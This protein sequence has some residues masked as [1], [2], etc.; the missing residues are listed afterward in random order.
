MSE[1]TR[2]FFVCDGRV[3]PMSDFPDFSGSAAKYIY[4][5]FRLE[6]GVPVFVEDHLDR[7]WKT[8]ELEHVSFPFSRKEIL[9]EIKL[10][11][12]ANHPG[13]GNIKIF[14][15]MPG[16]EPMQRLIYFNPHQYPT[17]AQFCEGVQLRLFHAERHNPNA[18]VMDPGLRGATDAI[19]STEK[20]YEVLLVDKHGFVTEGS[21]SNVFF[22]KNG[23]LI[24]PPLEAVLEGVTRKQIMN[25]CFVHNI[26]FAERPV[27][28][29]E[30]S[31]MYAAFISGTSR[32]VLPVNRIDDVG[33][34]A[35]NPLV[36]RMQ[37]L[38]DHLVRAYV[39]TGIGFWK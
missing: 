11:I 20:V 35:G 34:V 14:V 21:R 27:H 26:A 31:Q 2:D 1:F 10:L 13:N 28:H 17:E 33:F 3:T 37:S 29:T 7:L 30:L 5:V 6:D 19:K 12:K 36:R 38:L 23:V 8:A 39:E 24:T 32:R 16:S 22:V 15:S 9:Q 18:K 25:L 4:E